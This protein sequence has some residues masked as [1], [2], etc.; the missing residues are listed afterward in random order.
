MHGICLPLSPRQFQ[1]E[2]KLNVKNYKFIDNYLRVPGI[3]QV[4]FEALQIFSE[5]SRY[6]I[7]LPF[8]A[9]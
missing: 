8:M 6:L 9:L 5:N 2:N 7:A 4:N 3:A 1:S